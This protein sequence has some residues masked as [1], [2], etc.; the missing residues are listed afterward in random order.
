V[1]ERLRHRTPHQ[2]VRSSRRK[3]STATSI[4]VLEETVGGRWT[5]ANFHFHDDVPADV[6]SPP[7]ARICEAVAESFRE[8]IVQRADGI[9]CCGAR[10]CLALDKGDE[11]LVDRVVAE[12]GIDRSFATRVVGGTPHLA[13]PPLAISYGVLDPPDVVVGYIQPAS[14]MKL[15]R[16]WQQV[17]GTSPIVRLSTFMAICGDVVVGA[18]VSNRLRVS[19]GCRDSRQFGGVEDDRVIVGIPYVLLKPLLGVDLQASVAGQVGHS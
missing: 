16:Q 3:M 8:P 18:Y 14:A 13:I 6:L 2:H 11:E 10:R 17:Y 15:V 4:S 19:F 12:S 7:P 1:N 9:T 5:G